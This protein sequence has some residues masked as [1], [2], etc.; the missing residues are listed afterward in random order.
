MGQTLQQAS[1]NYQRDE[2]L[3][4]T[5][6]TAYGLE[7]TATPDDV[8]E[9][10]K[11]QIDEIYNGQISYME[12]GQYVGNGQNTFTLTLENTP[13]LIVICGNSNYSGTVITLVKNQEIIY[14]YGSGGYV[15]VAASLSWNNNIVTLTIPDNQYDG[16]YIMNSNGQTY[17]YV[18]I[19]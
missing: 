17:R 11:S 19:Y 14:V 16:R 12:Q 3:T 4:D 5:T 6:K 18:S 8:F 9:N 13:S 7:S 2:I 15:S 1:N 10:I